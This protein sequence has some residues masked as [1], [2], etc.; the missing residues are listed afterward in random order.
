MVKKI[1]KI[2]LSMMYVLVVL[3]LLLALLTQLEVGQQPLGRLVAGIIQSQLGASVHI[4]RL[5]GNLWHYLSCDDLI[6]YSNKDTLLSVRDISI[7][8]NPVFLM[9]RRIQVERLVV[10]QPRLHL[11]QMA[12]SSLNIAK[13]IPSASAS[14]SSRGR[15]WQVVVDTA[16]LRYGQ[17]TYKALHKSQAVPSML[18]DLNLHAKVVIKGNATTIR[19]MD[20]YG[21]L[22]DPDLRIR[23]FTGRMILQ[24]KTLALQDIR[25]QTDRSIL[26]GDAELVIKP[27]VIGMAHVLADPL[28]T[29]ELFAVWSGLKINGQPKVEVSWQW[30]STDLTVLA[31]AQQKGES[32]RLSAKGDRVFKPVIMNVRL[33]LDQIRPRTW[34]QNGPDAQV[35]GQ[36]RL[37]GSQWTLA[38]AQWSLDASGLSGYFGG[39][40]V[41][42]AAMLASLSDGQ[43]HATM[44]STSDWGVSQSVWAISD[45]PSAASWSVHFDFENINLARLFNIDTLYSD[46]NISADLSGQGYT[47]SALDANASVHLNP[48]TYNG[49]PIDSLQSHWRVHNGNLYVP[50][51]SLF[52]PVA[53]IQANAP[54]VNRDTLIINFH[55]DFKEPNHIRV[56]AVADSLHSRGSFLGRLYGPPDSLILDIA[57][58]LYKAQ[59]N[60]LYADSI[61]GTFYLTIL[62]DSEDGHINARIRN[63][64]V[65]MLPIDSV[66]VYTHLFSDS[67]HCTAHAFVSDSIEAKANFR[68]YW[69]H[70]PIRVVFAKMEA[71]IK[72]Q[73]WQGG[74]DSTR[75]LVRNQCYWFRDMQ[76]DHDDQRIAI[77]GLFSWTTAESLWGVWT[78]VRISQLNKV[79]PSLPDLDGS[80][81]GRFHLTGTAD[82]PKMRADLVVDKGQIDGFT[83]NRFVGEL[84]YENEK[85]V[86]QATLYHDAD[87]RVA[88]NGYLPLNL[89]LTSTKDV[90]YPDRPFQIGIQTQNL[91][92]A[93]LSNLSRHFRQVQGRLNCD[94]RLQNTLHNPQPSGYLSI[95]DGQVYVPATGKKYQDIQVD[96]DAD[97]SRLRLNRL[98]VKSGEGVIS[99]QGT[100]GFI[101]GGLAPQWQQ[102]NLALKA[103]NFS[104]LDT[105]DMA[106]VL[107]GDIRLTNSFSAPRFEGDVTV[108]RSRFNL[109]SLSDMTATASANNLP[110]LIAL[111]QDSAA[112]LA[113]EKGDSTLFKRLR[114]VRGSVR[115]E[116]PRN[117]WLRSPEMNI[118]ISGQINVVMN[119][120]EVELFG[121]IQMVR[122]DY[123]LYGRRFEIQ[124][125]TIT[126]QGGADVNPVVDLQAQHIFRTADKIKR[127]LKLQ[128]SGEI[129]EPKLT[130]L[131]DNSE[132]AETDAIAYLIFGRNFDALTQGQRTDLAQNQPGLDSNTFKELLA[133]QLAGEM[134][135]AIRNTLDLDVIEF[136]GDNNWRQATVVVGKY[137]T[138][139]LFV[140]YQREIKMGRTYDTTPEQVTMEYEITRS[141]FF[142]ATRGDEKNTGFDIIWKYEK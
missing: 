142:Q 1:L 117:T 115:I 76:L 138:N 135:K 97:S 42:D 122:G 22:Q 132:I 46:L 58:D 36:L 127:V 24:P 52:S 37:Q 11:V 92:L 78:N 118:E 98:Q 75:I 74:G 10:E 15:F 33:E 107:N 91:N 79:F 100:V 95:A 114:N 110:M 69:D 39:V 61:K 87:N 43:V 32:I 62:P 81:T 70:L 44:Q 96:V 38:K 139:D 112:A 17:V 19:V 90:L 134:T 41:R 86:W 31:N 21:R 113:S 140:S 125:G 93:F 133:G 121:T 104:A 84:A 85:A 137:I 5:H 108:V 105:R 50:T 16:L 6:I 94:L 49:Y 71:Q 109:P 73:L 29:N 130:F 68:T 131:L 102:L 4:G 64:R 80:T 20:L 116:I 120:T 55:G 7:T 34:L 63:G 60:A 106:M 54:L 30:N 99:G 51:L 8:W 23:S 136:K 111:Q 101:G 82:Q 119:G 35:S 141:L 12:D 129:L 124:S 48:S 25:L 67:L 57:A 40:T 77:N 128:V 83:Y 18:D 56:L 72:D 88:I 9:Q 103:D 27:K 13:I 65:S 53:D 126:F 59:Y 123:N 89:S 28:D 14:G 3:V 66:H 26:H 47:W 2:L 45:L